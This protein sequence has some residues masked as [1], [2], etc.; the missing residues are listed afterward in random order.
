MPFAPDPQDLPAPDRG[1]LPEGMRLLDRYTIIDRVGSGGIASIY[2]AMDERLD[3]VVCVK[4]LR[5]V[6][7]GSGS[8]AGGSVYQATY[9]HFL[10]EALALSK[11]QHPNTLRIYD[12]GYLDG[13]QS[14][15]AARS[16]PE[17]TGRP[18][19]ISEYLDGGNL[20]GRVRRN[21]PLAPEAIERIL[22]PICA[23]ITEAH[24]HRIIHRDIKPSNILFARIGETLV[25]KLADFG[26]ARS[27]LKKQRRPDETPRPGEDEESGAVSTVALF[28][29]RWAAPGQL[30]GA[31][32]GP[33]TDVYALGLLTAFMLTGKTPF[34]DQDV[35]STFSARVRSDELLRKRL[36]D[37]GVEGPMLATLLSAMTAD[38]AHRIRSAAEFFTQVRRSLAPKANPSAPPA[39]RPRS[40]QGLP[41][42]RPKMD[43]VTVEL[44]SLSE[45][46]AAPEPDAEPARPA[47][48]TQTIGRYR[49]RLVDVHEV[50][51]FTQGS[52]TGELR[53]RVTMLAVH[54]TPLRINIKGL[55]CFVAWA[56]RGTRPTP[57]IVAN[58]DGA[59]D[60]ISAQREKIGR[61]TWTF[62]T[63][64]HKGR[65]FLVDGEELVIPYGDATHAVVL[66][67]GD[68]REL[69]A[70]C[71][72]A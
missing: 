71:K 9:S 22:E 26:I 59:V 28:S 66:H 72:R 2:R 39:P 14:S 20:E 45:K 49:V 54:N 51:D 25:P 52:A 47:E 17:S 53:F 37:R 48:R 31:A 63:P 27:E 40:V 70:M 19:Q 55:N 5:L 46:E 50:L 38:P 16:A 15:V 41:P 8:T 69:V 1:E 44:E 4:L 10:Q 36:R 43:S 11:L 62:G 33:Y 29:P 32:E 67:L 18:F 21:G 61:V 58:Q 64:T 57:A 68:D 30:C 3:R 6:L 65:V 12:F 56:D 35:R 7:E 34:D 24:E 60:L 42:M 23:A 13:T